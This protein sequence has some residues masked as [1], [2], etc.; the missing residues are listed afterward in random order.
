MTPPIPLPLDPALLGTLVVIAF[1]SG[2]GI[3]TIGPGG[4]FLTISLYA[5]TSLPSGTIAGTAQLMFAVTGLVASFAYLRSGEIS[6]RT[7]L[8]TGLLS[9]GSVG[10]ALFGAWVNGFVSRDLFGLLLGVLAGVTGVLI[11]Y[12]ERRDLSPIRSFDPETPAGKA[13]YATLG[14]V[15]GAF[16]GL[17]GVGGPVIAVPALVVVG[18]PMLSAVAAAQVQSVFIATFAAVGYLLRGAVSVPLAVALGVPLTVGVVLGWGVAHRVDPDRLKVA[19]GG[20][21]LVVSPYLAL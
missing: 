18:V 21:L 10:G 15:L 3:T 8:W 7:R 11:V 5:L 9:V 17:L 20:V 6:G 4:I 19:L 13:A 12:R 1:V 16:S 2:V 14:F